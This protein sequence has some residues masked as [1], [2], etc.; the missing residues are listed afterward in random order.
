MTQTELP[1]DLLGDTEYEEGD[2]FT[3]SRDD[4]DTVYKVERITRTY[5]YFGYI[6]RGEPQH[7]MDPREAFDDNFS[8]GR[9]ELTDKDL[10]LTEPKIN[11][12][13]ASYIGEKI[14]E[15]LRD[16]NF[17]TAEDISSATDSEL[18]EIDGIGDGGVEGLRDLT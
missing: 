10:R 4:R 6:H 1:N 7:T 2:T 17:E 9:Y 15:R 11:L 5:V 14:A 18:K 16:N 12:T 8:A 13:D 3:D